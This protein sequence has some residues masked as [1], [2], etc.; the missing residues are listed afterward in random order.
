MAHTWAGACVLDSY[1]AGNGSSTATVRLMG[2]TG[3]VEL[4]LEVT[5]SGQLVHAAISLGETG[6]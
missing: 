4:A 2:A 3:S 5:D 6:P 1:L